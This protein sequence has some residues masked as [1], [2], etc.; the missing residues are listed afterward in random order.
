VQNIEYIHITAEAPDYLRD[1][2]VEVYREAFSGYPY[3]ETYESEEVQSDVWLPHLAKGIIVIAQDGGRVVGLGCAKPV[4]E[5]PLED[6]AFLRICRENQSLPHGT[7]TMWYMSEMAVLNEYRRKG[8]GYQ[9]VNERLKRILTLGGQHYSFRTASQ[10]SNSARL[11]L[12]I[13]AKQL[14]GVVDV[15]KTDQVQVNASQSHERL[16]F[17]GQCTEAIGI[18]ES[19]GIDDSH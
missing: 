3:F 14:P 5:A 17:H 15:S 16:F 6:Q 19:M 13:G 9:L 1:G 18:I 8:I 4:F 12:N 7:D 2:F 11:Y 10:G